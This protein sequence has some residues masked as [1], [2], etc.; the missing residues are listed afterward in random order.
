MDEDILLLVGP[1]KVNISAFH[2]VMSVAS[3][4]FRR[5]LQ[6][7]HFLEG[8]EL[9]GK[10][11]L[12][13][14]LIDDDAEAMSILCRIFHHQVDKDSFIT[15]SASTLADLVTL[16]DKYDCLKSVQ[17]WPDIWFKLP[18]IRKECKAI[19]RIPLSGLSKWAHISYQLR[20]STIFETCAQEIF[21]Q[22]SS[23]DFV[24]GPMV[25]DFQR[26]PLGLQ[27][28]PCP[29]HLNRVHV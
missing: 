12:E 29:Y 11:S 9:H 20:R 6:P 18:Q 4:V 2:Q 27:S 17:P 8:H 25:Q 22:A 13:L 3:P 24:E 15:L 21:L 10:G 28:K 14:V 23:S 5:M 7:T 16:I 19:H 26:L 1:E